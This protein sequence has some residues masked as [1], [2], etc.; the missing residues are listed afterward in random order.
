MGE[1]TGIYTASFRINKQMEAVSL[2]NVDT[3]PWDRGF[4]SHLG[5]D[6]FVCSVCVLYLSWNYF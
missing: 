5:M 3:H 2:L 6:V 4:E 1:Y